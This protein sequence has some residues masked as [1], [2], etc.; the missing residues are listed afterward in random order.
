MDERYKALSAPLKAR[1]DRFRAESPDFRIDSEE[2]EMVA[3][4]DADKIA[5]HLRPRVEAG[6]D[7]A[8]LVSEFY[9]LP[10]DE[11]LKIGIDPGHSGNTFGGACSLARA[12]LAGKAV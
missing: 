3:C 11:Q 6:E 12:L 4:V 10:W 9:D 2:Y 5:D 8:T 1:I 7:P